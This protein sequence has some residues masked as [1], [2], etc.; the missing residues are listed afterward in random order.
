MSDPHIG[1]VLAAYAIA[2]AT[3]LAMIGAVV[4]DYRALSGRLDEAG[5][6]LDA[7]RGGRKGSTP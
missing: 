3:I 1:F 2:G 6:A 7:A 5:R 4:A